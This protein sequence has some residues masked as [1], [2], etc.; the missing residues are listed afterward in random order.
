MTII[1]IQQFYES[2]NLFYEILQDFILSLIMPG[3]K[4]C[5]EQ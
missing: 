4:D 5:E 2:F 1:K 3:A